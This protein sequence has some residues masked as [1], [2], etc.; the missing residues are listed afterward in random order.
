M[1]FLWADAVP[2]AGKK[3]GELDALWP[4]SDRA[5]CLTEGLRLGAETFG[6]ACRRG[7]ETRAE[8]GDALGCHWR[9]RQCSSAISLVSPRERATLG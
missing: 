4:V 9:T 1:S 8:R 7:R 3:A 5:T 2:K 6:R